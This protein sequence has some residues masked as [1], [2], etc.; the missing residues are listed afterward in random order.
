MATVQRDGSLLRVET[1]SYYASVQTEGYVS[2]VKGSSFVD[3]ST[4]A[5]DQGFGLCIVDFLLEPGHDDDSTPS[6]LR[7]HGGN[8]VHGQIPKRYVEL[9]Q[10]CTQAKQLPTEI[11]EGNGFIAVRQE[12]TWM[13]ARP[14]NRGLAGSSG[15]F[16]PM[17]FAGSSPTTG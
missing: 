3:K 10:I 13:I 16:F 17:A 15:S 1:D 12:F 7:Y 6:A 4:G 5:C 14:T 2:G 11:V 9:P 8:L